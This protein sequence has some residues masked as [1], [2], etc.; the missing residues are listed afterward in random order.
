MSLASSRIGLSVIVPLLLI[1]VAFAAAPAAGQP[2]LP[3]SG[4]WTDQ[5]LVSLVESI[6]PNGVPIEQ[7][8]ITGV[9]AGSVSGTY[10]TTS[11]VY[12]ISPTQAYYYAVDDCTCTID[13]NG[14]YLIA[15]NEFGSLTLS[16]DGYY[17][18]LASNAVASATGSPNY[19]VSLQLQGTLN[20]LTD[21]SSGSYSGTYTSHP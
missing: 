3:A 9:I 4:T 20:P 21:L 15:F 13:G 12:V 2:S 6:G 17:Y 11:T 14:P 10:S 8:T 19:C 7:A 1:P 5:Q 16:Q 18:I